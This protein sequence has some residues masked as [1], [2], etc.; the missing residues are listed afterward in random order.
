MYELQ[1]MAAVA[2]VLGL[3]GAALWWLRR[4]GFVAPQPGRRS[5][6]R[7]ETVERLPIGPQ[8]ALH[9]VRLGRRALLVSS[10][11]SGCALLESVPWAEV[12]QQDEVAL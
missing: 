2:V 8:H 5:P 3:L 9:L 7:L 11:P 10:A 1:Q 12:E 4:R 6:R